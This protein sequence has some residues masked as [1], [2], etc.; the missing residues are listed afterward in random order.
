ML[1]MQ[2][3]AGDMSGLQPHFG[4]RAFVRLLH[5]V[6]DWLGQLVNS[7]HVLDNSAATT[8]R[9]S[10]S[11]LAQEI[12]VRRTVG[13]SIVLHKRGGRPRIADMSLDTAGTLCCADMS[14]LWV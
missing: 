12:Q 3:L 1:V 8:L 11:D 4:T 5:A 13:Q 10:T 7:S 6:E 14:D 9:T 2:A